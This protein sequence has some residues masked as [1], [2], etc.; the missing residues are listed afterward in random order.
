MLWH[1]RL[2]VKTAMP[3]QAGGKGDPLHREIVAMLFGRF[4]QQ[5]VSLR[6]GQQSKVMADLSDHPVQGVA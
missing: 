3:V 6:L 4:L 1:S 5:A 2:I